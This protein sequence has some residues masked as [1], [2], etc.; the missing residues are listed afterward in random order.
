MGRNMATAISKEKS[1]WLLITNKKKF[2]QEDLKFE[3]AGVTLPRVKDVLDLG[4]NFT[5]IAIT[6]AKDKKRHFLIK[7]PLVCGFGNQKPVLFVY[8]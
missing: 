3:L 6:I 8:F 2:N 1:K 4:V 7:K 5:H